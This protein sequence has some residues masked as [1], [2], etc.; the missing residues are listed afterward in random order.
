MKI[1]GIDTTTRFFCL[2]ISDN[3]KIYE[4]N[5]DVSRMLSGLITVTIKRVLDSLGWQIKDIDYF[6]CG[7]GP[8]SFTGMR[9]GIAAIK[10][11]AFSLNK[12]VAGIPTLD[13]LARNAA[14]LGEYVI[15]VVDAKRELIYTSIYRNKNNKLYRVEPYLL[16][17][18]DELFRKMKNRGNAV[19]LGDGA[20]LYKQKILMNMH[21]VTILDKDYWYP[22]GRNIIALAK[23]R[24]SS[25][26]FNKASGI[27]PVYLYPKECQIQKV[28]A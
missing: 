20:D 15:P 25:K 28:S 10:G 26:K 24:I 9:V 4:Y 14:T 11:L 6:A 7:L 8:G 19:M 17:T 1:F 2:G 12:P 21:D 5:L 23:E 16:L 3:A 22:Q 18:M 27:K 13:I